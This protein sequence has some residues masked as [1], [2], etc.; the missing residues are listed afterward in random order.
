M[1]IRQR[2]LKGLYPVLMKITKL[3]GK[4]RSIGREKVFLKQESGVSFYSLSAIRND[5]AAVS[6]EALKG[7]K[8]LLVNT[9]SGCGYTGQYAE[10]QKLHEQFGERLIILAFPANDFKEQEKESDDE[11]AKFCSVNYGVT[12][13]LMKKSVVILSPGQHPVYQ[14]LTHTE[15]NGWCSQPPE[16][17]FSK[18]LVNE[19]GVLTNYFAPSVSPLSKEVTEAILI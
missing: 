11:I 10:L 12:F 5:G 8:V 3:F 6:F 1:T 18:Y 4:D 14:W 15:K 9:A 13:P 19:A 16:W 7:R 2:I 17:N